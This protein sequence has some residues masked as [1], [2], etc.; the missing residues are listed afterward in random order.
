ML[1]LF[2]LLFTFYNFGGVF[3]TLLNACGGFFVRI[4]NYLMLLIAFANGFGSDVSLGYEFAFE[5]AL[6]Q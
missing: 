1:G 5:F 3:G 6:N 2:Y 4:V